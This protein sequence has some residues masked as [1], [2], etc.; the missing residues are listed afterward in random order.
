MASR[1]YDDLLNA[2]KRYA[3][4]KGGRVVV[5]CGGDPDGGDWPDRVIVAGAALHTEARAETLMLAARECVRKAQ[6]DYSEVIDNATEEAQWAR[7]DEFFAEHGIDG[8]AVEDG[9]HTVRM[10]P[11][12]EPAPDG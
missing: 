9:T 1:E 5:L 12:T 2:S 11:I 6:I 3:A 10:V 4:A 7:M 8:G